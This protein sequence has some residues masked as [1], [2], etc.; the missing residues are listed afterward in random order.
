MM[1]RSERVTEKIESA[2]TSLTGIDLLTPEQLSTYL[3]ISRRTIHRYMALG[4]PYE[5]LS[6]RNARYRLSDVMKWIQDNDPRRAR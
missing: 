1:K 6:K 5:R 4:M 2:A 3:Q